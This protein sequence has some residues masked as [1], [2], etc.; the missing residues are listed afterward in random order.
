MFVLVLVCG[1]MTL[2]LILLYL[3]MRVGSIRNLNDLFNYIAY[4]EVAGVAANIGKKDGLYL[5]AFIN[6]PDPKHPE[7]PKYTLRW[8]GLPVDGRGEAVILDNKHGTDDGKGGIVGYEDIKFSEH[9]PVPPICGDP[10]V[11]KTHPKGFR[12]E[13]EGKIRPML[14]AHYRALFFADDSLNAHDH[15][16]VEIHPRLRFNCVKGGNHIIEACPDHHTIHPHTFECV[17][18]NECVLEGY[19]EGATY[20][21]AKDPSMFWQCKNKEPIERKCADEHIYSRQVRTC[22]P[23]NM[24]KP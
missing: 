1:I 11:D 19:P 18:F 22:V 24:Y 8:D 16:V 20:S 3:I 23:L 14:R 9:Y 2:L 15:D 5:N 17:P 10:T 6:V 13:H 12:F 4:Y 7:L 21:H